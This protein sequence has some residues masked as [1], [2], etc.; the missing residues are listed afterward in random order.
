MTD[1]V[2]IQLPFSLTVIIGS[3]V[4]MLAGCSGPETTEQLISAYPLCTLS[5]TATLQLYTG[6]TVSH[7]ALW[8]F[9][10]WASLEEKHKRKSAKEIVSL[11]CGET[12]VSLLGSAMSFFR[13][14]SEQHE[15]L[16]KIP[17]NG[18]RWRMHFWYTSHKK[19]LKNQFRRTALSHR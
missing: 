9:S 2:G 1:W 3:F 15:W 16:V 7:S 11:D 19:N 14:I 5:E 12:T 17:C 8:Y 18:S 6:P 13:L 10:T 4:E